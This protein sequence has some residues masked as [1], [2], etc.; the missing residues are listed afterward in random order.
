[1]EEILKKIDDEISERD[2]NTGKIGVRGIR[3]GIGI[4]Q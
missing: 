1:M 2:N 3:C 4:N